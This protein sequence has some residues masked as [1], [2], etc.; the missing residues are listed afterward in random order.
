MILKSNSKIV[1]GVFLVLLVY[2]A[3]INWSK[4]QWENVIEADG[5]GY[6]AYL[7]A[8]FIYHD[9]NLGF[10]N[11]VEVENAYDKTLYYDYRATVNGRTID[12]Y[13]IGES[14]LITPFFLIA[15]GLS[16][17]FGFPADGYSQLYVVFLTVASLFYVCI[18]LVFLIKTFILYEIGGKQILVSIMA[19]LFGTNLFYY[20][21]GEVAM[22][23][24]YSFALVSFF[25]Y[26][27]KSYFT[28]PQPVHV[29][30][31]SV[32]YALIILVRPVNFLVIFSIPFLSGTR[33]NFIGGMR[34]LF[35]RK[36][37]MVQSVLLMF[38]ILSLQLT[39]YKLQT[40]SFF[41]YSYGNEGFDF[42]NP[43][44]SDFLFS[45]KKGFFLYTPLCMVALAGIIPMFK[46]KF[47]FFGMAFFLALVIYVLSSWWMWYYGGS[48][49]SR[50]MV[51]YLPFFFILLAN[52]L[53]LL[54]R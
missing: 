27:V 21:I 28:R 18:G 16:L 40:G 32:A 43:H 14:V 24:V 50:V 31:T 12:K 11:R 52:I 7:P 1:F 44:F 22:S 17:L 34:D 13:F 47:E 33:E 19:I 3:K 30:C 5:K 53:K 23:H 15:H 26:Q 8:V 25:I 4:G 46:R 29:I 51:E 49:S 9:L 37:L 35:S 41:V 42:S 38:V 45:Y 39:V 6:Y 2:T 10:Y 54:V 36:Y 48:F 20:S